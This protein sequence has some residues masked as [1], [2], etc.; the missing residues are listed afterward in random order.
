MNKSLIYYRFIIA[1]VM[2]FCL[3]LSA[4]AQQSFTVKGVIFRK[5]TPDIV[6]QALVTNLTRKIN[7]MSDE[8]GSFHI[9]AA[10]GDTLL[11]KKNDYAA[12]ILVVIT[13]LDQTIYM[14][15]IIHLN[16]VT[17]KDKSRKDELNEVMDDY[18]KK[19]Q[20]YTL[21]PSA[22]SLVN[23]PLTG[24]YEIFGK[25][26]AQAKRFRQYS[27]DELERAAVAKRY[28]KKLILQVTSMPDIE[29]QDFMLAFTP[30]YEDIKVWSDYDIISY[31]KRN[32]EYYRNNKSSL[33][34]EKLY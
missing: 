27:K 11:F 7:G 18:K 16:E 4:S 14:Q 17:I 29:V 3:A 23:S 5:N 33:K 2:C 13:R 15:P 9:Q 31:I 6:P 32:Y 30:S 20:Y 25:G 26:A 21:N 22:W 12:Q 24:L 10:M 8:L 19:N 34:I 1:A 28:N